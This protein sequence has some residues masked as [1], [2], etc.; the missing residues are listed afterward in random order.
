[1]CSGTDFLYVLKADDIQELI[2]L[3]LK[4]D[5]IQ[6]LI[7]LYVLKADDFHVFKN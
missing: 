3:L 5:D 6:E 2:F 7:F 1:M 4:A